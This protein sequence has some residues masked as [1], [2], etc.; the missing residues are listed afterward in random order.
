VRK[1]KEATHARGDWEGLVA[2]KICGRR[3]RGCGTRK[4][5]VKFEE[6]V[7]AMKI[8]F[9]FQYLLLGRFSRTLGVA[10]TWGFGVTYVAHNGGGTYVAHNAASVHV[11]ADLEDEADIGDTRKVLVTCF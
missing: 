5:S 1:K 9:I 2:A 6:G 4:F 8:R 3:V 7:G 10:L 11:T